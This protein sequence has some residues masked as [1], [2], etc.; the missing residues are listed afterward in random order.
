ML[1]DT[2]RRIEIEVINCT[3][4]HKLLYSFPKSYVQSGVLQEYTEE[5]SDSKE[6]K[7]GTGLREE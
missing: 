3:V 7:P 6:R 5:F 4:S 1:C 2:E